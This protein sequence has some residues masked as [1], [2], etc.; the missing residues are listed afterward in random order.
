MKVGIECVLVSQYRGIE[1]RRNALIDTGIGPPA[2]CPH[3]GVC[4]SANQ[5][6]LVDF[7]I[8]IT[9]VVMQ[10]WRR[11]LKCFH[12]CFCL[13]NVI[14]LSAFISFRDIS[15]QAQDL[16][17]IKSV[18]KTHCYKYGPFIQY[19]VKRPTI[20]DHHHLP[21]ILILRNSLTIGEAVSRG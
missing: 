1:Y 4:V 5:Q 9:N 8:C 2:V 15:S 21:T 17:A 14:K 18:L 19:M 16:L 6:Y 10:G 12:Y 7:T 3:C 11:Y 20:V 13:L